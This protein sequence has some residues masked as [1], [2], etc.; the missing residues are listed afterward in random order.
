MLQDAPSCTSRLPIALLVRGGGGGGT[1]MLLAS[2]GPAQGQ[3]QGLL[4]RP[5]LQPQHH[6]LLHLQIWCRAW[7]M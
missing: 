6:T 4:Q 3:C 5:Q 7:Q 1:H 2:R